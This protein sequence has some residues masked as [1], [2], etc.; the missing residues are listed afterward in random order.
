[1][2]DSIGAAKDL[3]E[4]LGPYVLHRQFTEIARPFEAAKVI[5]RLP[6]ATEKL[7]Q[8][9]LRYSIRSIMGNELDLAYRYLHLSVAVWSGIQDNSDFKDLQK[10]RLAGKDEKKLIYQRLKEKS[11][12]ETRSVSYEP[13]PGSIPLDV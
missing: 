9:C 13:P 10:Y 6:A 5:D 12:L 8:L 3:I 11:N 2:N 7:S 4:I 1:M